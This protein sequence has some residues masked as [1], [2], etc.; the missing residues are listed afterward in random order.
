ML[1]HQTYNNYTS[2]ASWTGKINKLRERQF[3]ISKT[4]AFRN[5]GQY[6]YLYV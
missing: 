6:G 4:R 3:T 1:D 2:F 5:H